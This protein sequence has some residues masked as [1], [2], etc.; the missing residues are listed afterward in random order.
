MNTIR[1]ILSLAAHFGY[2][3]QQFDVKNVLLHKDL[4]VYMGI[5]T[6]FGSLDREN[7]VYRLK[8]ALHGLKESL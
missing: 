7:K 8:N 5:P 3:L 6:R 4:E 1:V 2:H